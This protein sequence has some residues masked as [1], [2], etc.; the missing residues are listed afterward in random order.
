MTVEHGAQFVQVCDRD[1][2]GTSRDRRA[3][4]SI[5]HPRRQFSREARLHLDIQNLAAAPA[6]PRVDPNALA[7]KRVPGI[8][9]DNKL[10]TVC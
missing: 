4:R 10:R 2:G 8:F 1:S 3:D 5:A 7:V 6:V 9:H